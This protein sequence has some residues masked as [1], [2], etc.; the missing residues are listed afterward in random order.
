[1]NK[2]FL[3]TLLDSVA[4]S[5]HEIALQ[6]QVIQEMTPHCDRIMTDYTG[7]VISVL[8]PDAPFKVLLTGHIDEIGLI[9]TNI[10]SDGFLRVSKV[11]GIYPGLYP[12][13]QV[14]VCGRS[15]IVHGTVV[16][17]AAAEKPVS[18]PSDLVIDIGAKDE[19]DARRYVRE[20]DPICPNTHHQ[21]M[22]NGLLSAR[23][24][25]DRS[26]VFIILEALK[27]A[28]EKGCR[29]GVYAAATVGEETTMR[30]AHWA[31]GAV[32]PDL[33]IAVDV[34]FAQDYPGADPNRSGNI[35]LGRGPALCNSSIVSPRLNEL[36]LA[37]AAEKHIPC[38]V[39]TYVGHTGTDADRIHFSGTGVAT[40]LL[41]LPIRYMHAPSE[42][43]HLDDIEH[44][45]ELLSEF[46]CS[47][48]EHTDL[49][50]F[51]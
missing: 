23:A 50:P 22:A 5:G 26:G 3:Y 17:C 11:G 44:A 39:E 25:D 14:M 2:A 41:S 6:K 37:C 20:G 24:I 10:Q 36:L 30:G 7:N 31:A 35:R 19:E 45:I 8:N 4:V 29:I 1:M 27:Q 34:T 33:G 43:C 15:G 32:K 47:I 16:H 48:D 28:R 12:G 51:H 13:H 9:V 40:A 21:E 42:V 46:L 38:Q 49:D 18:S